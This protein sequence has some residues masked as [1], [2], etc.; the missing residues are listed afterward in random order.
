MIYTSPMSTTALKKKIVVD[1]HG[2]PL[3]VIIAWSDY[4][5]LAE[6]MGWDL[7]EDEAADVNEA[8]AD[9]RSGNP[10]AFIAL[11]ELNLN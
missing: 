10:E 8:M 1:E 4:Q 9:W 2:Q 3:E 7:S 11:E 6:R 5:D